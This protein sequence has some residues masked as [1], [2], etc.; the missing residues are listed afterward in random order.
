[1]YEIAIENHRLG[2][3]FLSIKTGVKET[4]AHFKAMSK[5]T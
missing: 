3:P 1:M 2:T 5:L 4:R